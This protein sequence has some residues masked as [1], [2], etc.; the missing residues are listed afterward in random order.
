MGTIP[1]TGT[2]ITMNQSQPT[3]AFG[4]FRRI[5][6][7]HSVNKTY[8]MRAKKINVHNWLGVIH[9]ENGR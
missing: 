3:N 8:T 2:S 4:P 1:H 5:C 9:S 7:T 6:Q